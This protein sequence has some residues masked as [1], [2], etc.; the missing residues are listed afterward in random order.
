MKLVPAICPNCGGAIKLNKEDKTAKCPFC[1]TPFIVDEAINRYV[2]YQTTKVENLYAGQVTINNDEREKLLNAGHSFLLL[3][4]FNSAEDKFKEVTET[5]PGDWRGWWGLIEVMFERGL[6]DDE[7]WVKE[8]CIVSHN[9]KTYYS[10]IEKLTEGKVPSEVQETGTLIRKILD[11]VLKKN[12]ALLD[13]ED[14]HS[15]EQKAI[16]PQYKD[17]TDKL[18]EQSSRNYSRICELNSQVYANGP[19]FWHTG[20][21][22]P[23][24]AFFVGLVVAAFKGFDFMGTV[25]NGLFF[26]LIYAVIIEIVP[27][28]IS[29]KKYDQKLKEIDDLNAENRDLDKKRSEIEESIRKKEKELAEKIDLEKQKIEQEYQENLKKLR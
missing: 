19:T 1:D 14:K 18:R 20:V 11:L 21:A 13:L 25:F 22:I 9:F 4:D 17:S 29:R 26:L 2:K 8:H 24:G 15:K 12:V 27:Y 10:N 28:N 3:K 6:K 23:F 16:R 7:Y 5:Y